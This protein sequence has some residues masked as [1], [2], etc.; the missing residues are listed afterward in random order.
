MPN[1][2]KKVDKGIYLIESNDVMR[3]YKFLLKQTV[4]VADK[5]VASKETHTVNGITY[6]KALEKMQ[7]ERILMRE[8]IINK[9]NGVTAEDIEEDEKVNTITVD[10]LW[11]DFYDANK[12]RWSENYCNGLKSNYKKLV[13]PYLGSKRAITVKMKHVE[14]AINALPKTYSLRSHYSVKELVRGMYKWWLDREEID[15]RNP[16]NVKLQK[17]NNAKNIKLSWEDIT[18][19]YKAMYGYKDDHYRQ[20]F[21]WL[22]TGRR[23]GELLAVKKDHLDGMYYTIIAANNKANTDMI[24]HIPEGATIPVKHDFVF[25]ATRNRTRQLQKGTVDKV[26]LRLMKQLDMSIQKHDL[27]H[28]ITLKLREGA[29]P[30]EIRSM[31]LG[32]TIHSIT[33]RY[34]TDTKEGADL[35]HKA[36]TFFLDKVFNKIDRKMMWDEY[37]IRKR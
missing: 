22:S 1:I 33:E 4:T 8:R 28:V 17:L 6:K 24:Y 13:K 3:S 12:S 18:K 31:V 7:V 29:V 35:K 10:E 26:W 27:R 36:V 15:K 20:V 23:I 16:A 11:D 25:Q 34:S 37:V 9:A 30:L 32:H 5:K 14:D 21:I 19:L 2:N